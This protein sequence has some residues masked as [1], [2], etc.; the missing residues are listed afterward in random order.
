MP[1][2]ALPGAIDDGKPNSNKKLS[3]LN[4][5]LGKVLLRQSAGTWDQ[6]SLYVGL[7]LWTG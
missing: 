2:A 6:G 3:K 5:M 1:L 7:Y 4:S